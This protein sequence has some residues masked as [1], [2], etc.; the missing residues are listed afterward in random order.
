MR[1][2]QHRHQ[3]SKP[4]GTLL[5]HGSVPCLL[6]ERPLTQEDVNQG[7]V[8]GEGSMTPGTRYQENFRLFCIAHFYRKVDGQWVEQPDYEANC[9]LLAMKIAARLES[10]GQL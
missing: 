3:P 1:R 5:I 4:A 9:E 2:H 7:L 10:E 6:C 8:M